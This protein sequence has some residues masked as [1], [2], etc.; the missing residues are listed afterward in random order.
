MHYGESDNLDPK[1]MY[2]SRNYLRYR[3]MRGFLVKIGLRLSVYQPFVGF[4][5]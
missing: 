1:T 3:A 4:G 2:I 5:I